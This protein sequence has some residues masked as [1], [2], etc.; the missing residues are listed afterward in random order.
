MKRTTFRR[1]TPS[2]AD[3]INAIAHK[4][5]WTTYDS[6]LSKEQ[7]GFMLNEM[8]APTVL[9]NNIEQGIGFFMVELDQQAVGFTSFIPK[10]GSS[11]TYRIEKLYLLEDAQGYG[12]GKALVN[13]VAKLAKQEGFSIL[14]LNVNR[15]N[16]ASNFY[17]KLGF[18]IVGEVDIPYHHFVLND[19]IMQKEI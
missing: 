5:W 4:S 2:D 11:N 6:F 16:P 18:K 14:E 9:Y 3:V 8:Y 17:T 10:D 12:L 19:Y 13:E 7:I 1:C 15:Y